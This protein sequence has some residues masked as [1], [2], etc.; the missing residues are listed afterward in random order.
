MP[1]LQPAFSLLYDWNATVR[2][3]GDHVYNLALLLPGSISKTESGFVCSERLTFRIV[4]F[5]ALFELPRRIDILHR[6]NVWYK[7]R[8]L[9]FQVGSENVS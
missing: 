2:P 1:A 8:R 9:V 6:E 3:I 7:N 5:V 4:L